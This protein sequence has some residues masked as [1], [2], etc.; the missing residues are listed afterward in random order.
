MFT[1][2]SLIGKNIDQFRLEEVI[3]QGA[4]GILYKAFDTILHR[5]VALKI[6]LKDGESPTPE[7]IIARKRLIQEAQAAGRLAHPNIVTIHSYGETD[8]FQYICMEYIMGKTLGEM[9]TAQHVLEVEDATA[10]IEQI[11]IALDVANK[12]NII[13]R[14]IKPNNIMVM[15]DRRIKVM[16]FGIAKLPSLSMTST[17]SILG[18]PYYMSPEQITGQKVD[19]RSDLFSVGTVLYQIITGVRPFEGET[20]VAVSYKI[21]QVE[22]VPPKVLNVHIPQELDNICK[23]ALAKDPALRYQTPNDMLQ[24]LRYFS[25]RGGVAKPVEADSTIIIKASDLAPKAPAENREEKDIAPAAVAEEKKAAPIKEEKIEPAQKPVEAKPEPPPPASP[26][27]K[28]PEPVK[29]QGSGLKTGM[30]AFG[31]IIV[32]VIGSVAV[33]R[34]VR[35]GAQP[36]AMADLAN[37]PIKAQGAGIA[38]SKANPANQNTAS[39][40]TA[41]VPLKPLIQQA[42]DQMKS[43]P[44]HARRLFEQALAQAP[45]NFEANYHLARLL[46]NQNDFQS[47]VPLFKKAQRI[48]SRLPEIPYY[49]GAIYMRQGDYNQALASYKTCRTIS[50]AFKEDRLVFKN[51]I[52]RVKSDRA[53]SRQYQ[54]EVSINMGI[55]YLK[56]NDKKRSRQY[57][58]EALEY[59]PDNTV[60]QS[61]L[62]GE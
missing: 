59:N 34:V 54:E 8:E 43:N 45:N 16:D 14:D 18:T 41:S 24:D 32:I 42:K 21:T 37:Q 40:N 9:I 17:G 61:Y 6:I 31:L 55:C 36:N 11:L 44:S 23:K 20:T 35:K 27:V 7:M 50:P 22:P 48:D 51:G 56:M 13:H 57:F 19:I 10:I 49:L 12:E 3:G 30:I 47:A 28:A 33:M 39:Q 52:H 46:T 53:L 26:K 1:P 4:M 25:S 2:S 58:R 60:A 62:K 29:T 38:D 5:T 15:A